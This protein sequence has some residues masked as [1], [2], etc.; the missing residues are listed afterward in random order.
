MVKFATEEN[1]DR[2]NDL[3]NLGDLK[4]DTKKKRLAS[5]NSFRQF[6][7]ARRLQDVE[8]LCE[9]G[10]ELVMEKYLAEFFSNLTKNDG[11]KPKINYLD[12]IVSNVKMGIKELSGNRID[13]SEFRSLEMVLK[14][15]RRELKQMGLGDTE[16]YKPASEDDLK[17]IYVAF[18]SLAKFLQLLDAG[19]YEL[20]LEEQQNIPIAYRDKP[21]VFLHHANLFILVCSD[22]RRG[23]DGLHE[24]KRDSYILETNT[25]GEKYFARAFN[26]AT[27]NHQSYSENT[28]NAGIIPFT[29]DQNGY[30]PGYLLECMIRHLNPKNDKLF[31]RAKEGGNGK[32]FDMR[33]SHWYVNMAIGKNPIGAFLPTLTESLGINRYTNHCLR[34]TSIVAL[35][36]A[37]FDA[38]DIIKIIGHKKVESLNNYD[39]ELGSAK[40]A[41]MAQVLLNGKNSAK[42]AQAV[43]PDNIHMGESSRTVS[44]AIDGISE[45]QVT[46]NVE[47]QSNTI[48]SNNVRQ[49]EE[50]AVTNVI[51]P[52]PAPNVSVVQFQDVQNYM[53]QRN[54]G[55]VSSQSEREQN[56][57]IMNQLEL[58]KQ[59]LLML[60]SQ[61]NMS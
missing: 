15:A 3:L 28:T 19:N 39:H 25:N 18:G 17:V 24:L 49:I 23:R 60:Q 46:M 21:H 30:N 9:I 16:R 29:T 44:I 8:T 57:I 47:Q 53:L 52:T 43:A 14:G 58:M 31:Q 1:P 12:H 56:A 11:N 36:R 33:E 35:D 59:Q 34:T 38:R 4:A 7:A 27:K 37:G 5:M 40:K 22:V 55:C 13:I 10:N 61:N 6:L 54:G 45:E 2:A 32:Y 50:R 20:A 41:K 26:G 51:E 48:P 42:V